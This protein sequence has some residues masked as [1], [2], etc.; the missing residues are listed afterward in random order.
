MK[1]TDLPRL[2]GVNY[3]FNSSGMT[4]RVIAHHIADVRSTLAAAFDLA[5]D[6]VHVSHVPRQIDGEDFRLT[7]LAGANRT[8]YTGAILAAKYVLPR[9]RVARSEP[10][11]WW[12]PGEDDAAD[13]EA[14][15]AIAAGVP[16]PPQAES[17]VRQQLRRHL[18]PKARQSLSA[19]CCSQLLALFRDTSTPP[20]MKLC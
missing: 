14:L 16:C 1:P 7:A 10:L 20:Y 18:S 11:A 8:D 6:A 13:E 3:S 5:P 9:L 4:P 17:W 2:K 15:A 12:T 19:R